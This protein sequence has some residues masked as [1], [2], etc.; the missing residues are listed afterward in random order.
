MREKIEVCDLCAGRDFSAQY[1]MPDRVCGR[2]EVFGIVQCGECGLV[3]VNPR[4]MEAEI[5]AYYPQGYE[6]YQ[7]VTGF[8]RAVKW[9]FLRSD[10]ARM[11]RLV[12]AGGRILDVGTGVG[13]D[14]AFLRDRG[15]WQ[16]QATDAS[17]FAAAQ[18]QKHF[19]LSV[20]VGRLE[21]LGLPDAA[22]D[23]VRMRYVLSHVH[24]PRREL[25]E[26]RRILKPG[27]WLV[28]WVPNIDS[29]SWRAFGSNWEG[30]E[31]PRHLYDFSVRT[32]SR[33][34]TDAQFSVEEIRHSIVPNTFIHSARNFLSARGAP[35]L[36]LKIFTLNPLTLALFL[37]FSLIAAVLC[38]SD[39]IMIIAK[40]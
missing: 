35:N 30:G 2:G 29:L 6:S 38:K 33:Y 11:R 22:Y 17:E 23:V 13:E 18:A 40:R 20:L 5:G 12:P 26:V 21:S 19:G 16:V 37:P 1:T 39:R 36:L 28:L 32:L 15:A 8:R 31:A 10:L 27:G 7:P 34:L 9:L 25:A 14:A 4:P 3:F 24:S